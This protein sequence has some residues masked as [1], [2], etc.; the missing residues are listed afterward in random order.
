MSSFKWIHLNDDMQYFKV[1]QRCLRILL[2]A[3][4][5]RP[6]SIPAI[7]LEIEQ[8]PDRRCSTLIPHLT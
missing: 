1:F 3:P 5:C 7:A 4:R 2:N 8:E 6:V